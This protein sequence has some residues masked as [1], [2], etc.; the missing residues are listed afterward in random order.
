MADKIVT[1]FVNLINQQIISQEILREHIAKVEALVY[2]AMS[3]VFLGYTK[4]IGYHYLWVIMDII[5]MA[6]VLNEDS[7]NSLLKSRE[8]ISEEQEQ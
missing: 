2:V 5:E 7:L 6:K 3:E 1:Q 4:S 8:I